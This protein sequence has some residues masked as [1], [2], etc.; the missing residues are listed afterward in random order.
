MD[1][2]SAASEPGCRCQMSG[3][4]CEAK[5]WNACPAS[6]SRVMTSSTRP[7]RVHEDEGATPVVQRLAVAARR[8]ALPAVEVE[9]AL[10]DHGLELAAERGI[11]PV[12][13]PRAPCRRTRS[14]VANGRSGV[15]R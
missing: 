15:L 12:E 9:Q 14:V 13:D 10:V 7:D 8:L 6:C 3:C 5:A 2:S 1:A 4:S 11:D